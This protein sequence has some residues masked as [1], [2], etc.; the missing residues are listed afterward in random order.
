MSSRLIF[1][2]VLTMA[3]E[4]ADE[5]TA[6]DSIFPEST[7]EIA[8]F[9]YRF[10]IP[11]TNEV[12]VEITFPKEYPQEI[13]KVNQVIS[14]DMIKFS[15]NNYLQRN[16]QSTLTRVFH[17]G[18]VCIFE[19]LS[20]L[21]VFLEEYKSNRERDSAETAQ[22]LALENDQQR[23]KS[24]QVETQKPVETI[25]VDPFE[26]WIASEPL[27]DRGSTFIGFSREVHSLDETQEALDLLTL[28]RKILRATH[29]ISAW[30]IKGEKGVQ[31]QDCDDD[32]ETAAGGRLL[33]LL[34]V[35]KTFPII[36]ID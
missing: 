36:G 8:P 21:E 1:R 33:H 27:I 31:Y 11:G 6:I 14:H 7:C 16:I 12:E 3:D 19:L 24:P 23:T 13:P 10:K 30:R 18:E 4:L 9:V 2:G 5:V 15:D 26:G 29:N 28:D 20:E 32:G 34:T 25:Q 22:R 35:S 17:K